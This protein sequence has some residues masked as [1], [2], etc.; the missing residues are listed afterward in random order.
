MLGVALAM[1]VFFVS[2]FLDWAGAG[3]LASS[4]GIDANSWWIAF[5]LAVVAAGLFAAEA[6]NYPPPFAWASLG[7]GALSA[8]LVFFWALTHLIDATE[9]P[10]SP[11]LGAW[12]GLIVS[13][14]GAALAI[15]S[16]YQE[17]A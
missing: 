1:V 11:Q 3:D 5:G 4:N 16:W 7:I 2:L 6:L 12:I 10:I 17:R 15:T 8:L 14:I 9:G 13:A